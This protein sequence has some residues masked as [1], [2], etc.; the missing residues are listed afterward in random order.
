MKAPPGRGPTSHRRGSRPAR[1]ALA[2]G[3]HP[4]LGPIIANARAPVQQETTR[5]SVSL[6]R[7]V[8]VAI[9]FVQFGDAFPP[10][11]R[12]CRHAADSLPGVAGQF[13][14]EFE[15]TVRRAPVAAGSCRRGRGRVLLIIPTW[16]AAP[17]R[18]G[19]RMFAPDRIGAVVRTESRTVEQAARERVGRGESDGPPVPAVDGVAPRHRQRV[20]AIEAEPIAL[21]GQSGERVVEQQ[22]RRRPDRRDAASRRRA[23]Q[24][25]VAR[26]PRGCPGP[27]VRGRVMECSRRESIGPLAGEG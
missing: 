14:L 26:S 23:L 5:S 7:S 10:P 25:A 16:S 21:R 8:L 13:G 19:Q 24:R 1:T 12:A 17:A 20:G 2:S 18:L 27:A 4:A 6:S 9:T 11:D 3:R 15:R 22:R